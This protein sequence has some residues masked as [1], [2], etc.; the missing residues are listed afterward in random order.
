MTIDNGKPM[1][2]SLVSPSGSPRGLLMDVR[3]IRERTQKG[4]QREGVI[5]SKQELDRIKS[6]M[7]VPPGLPPRNRSPHV[8]EQT[9]K[10]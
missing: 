5:I 1:K 3:S 9:L 2:P 8:D 10:M 4:E 6:S 7:N